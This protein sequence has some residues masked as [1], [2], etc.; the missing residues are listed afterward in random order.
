MDLHVTEHRQLTAVQKL[1]HDWQALHDAAGEANPFTGPDWALTWLDHFAGDPRHEPLVLE[2]RDGD[3]LVGIAPLYRRSV[4]RGLATLVQ[5][6]G[7]GS[8]W[9]GPYEQPALLTDPTCARDV[10]RAVVGHLCADPTG[11]DVAQFALGENVPWFE[12]EWLPDW[13]YTLLQRR[14]RPSAVLRLEGVDNVYAGR[15]NLKESLRRARNRLTREVGADGWSVRRVTDPA[16]LPAAFDRLVALHGER[17][18]LRDGR[19][20]HADIYADPRVLAY[21]RDVVTRAGEH[22]GASVYELLVG[23]TVEASQLVLHTRSASYSSTSG[24]SERAWP[25]SA[26]TYLLS[27]AVKDAQEAGHRVLNLSTGPN[28]AK[29][30]WTDEV[31]TST[32]FA[33]VGRRRRSKALTLAL[34]AHAVL[35]GFAE[36]RR[37]HRVRLTPGRP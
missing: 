10:A 27:L 32:E 34:D 36:A 22:G 4:L 24:V 37:A 9:I 14:T 3:R 6:I 11:W 8:L 28:Q 16:L 21:L 29:L 12:P 25:Y 19:P 33:V 18:Q 15:R 17:S 26:V 1:A 2:V 23:E 5:P 35:A 20:V 13:S 31:R 7:T 30:R